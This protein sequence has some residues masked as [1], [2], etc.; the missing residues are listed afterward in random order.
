MIHNLP[1]METINKTAK[2]TNLPKY[3]V[4]QLVLQRKI[5][6]VKAGKKYLV[7][8]DNLIEYLKKTFLFFTCFCYLLS[9]A[10]FTVFEMKKVFLNN[11]YYQKVSANL[12]EYINEK[13][14][15]KELVEENLKARKDTYSDF[16]KKK[17]LY[18]FIPST[19]LGATSGIIIVLDFINKD[20]NFYIQ[21]ICTCH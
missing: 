21:Q 9:V 2:I 14:S 19:F 17:Q 10:I 13:M 18:Y 4:R 15:K 20:I 8:V 6:Y 5:K 3:F 11:I 7:N 16:A 1:Q 12:E